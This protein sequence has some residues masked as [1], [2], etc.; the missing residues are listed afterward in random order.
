MREDSQLFFFFLLLNKYSLSGIFGRANQHFHYNEVLATTKYPPSL[1]THNV[2]R[3]WK[4]LW[5]RDEEPMK[6]VV[7][8]GEGLV[9]ESNT[10]QIDH[11]FSNKIVEEKV[12]LSTDRYIY[13]P[14]VYTWVNGSEE[15]YR[16]ERRRECPPG[17]ECIGTPRGKNCDFF[18]REMR[19]G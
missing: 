17:S 4:S 6:S 12:N 13:I 3:T 19:E 1:Y 9:V 7:G 15:R 2:S 5:Y 11:S 8:A 10:R 16:D 18:Y 14:L